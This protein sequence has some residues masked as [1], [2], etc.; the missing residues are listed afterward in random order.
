MSKDEEFE[1]LVEEI[2]REGQITP[3]QAA[4]IV[5]WWERRPTIDN[6]MAVDKDFKQVSEWMQQKP[7]GTEKVFPG[8][9]R[10]H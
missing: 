1:M 8:I 4:K 6:G 10:P 7:E 9:E 3:E 2:V 5:A